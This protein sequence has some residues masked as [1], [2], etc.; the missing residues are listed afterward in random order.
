MDENKQND[1]DTDD[2]FFNDVQS[3]QEQGACGKENASD[4]G[5]TGDGFFDDASN[6]QGRNGNGYWGENPRGYVPVPT[7]S[8]KRTGKLIGKIFAAIGIA[9]VVFFSGMLTTWVCLDDGMRTLIKIKKTIDREY[10]QDVSDDEFYR[11]LF[12]AINDDLLDPY[13][14]Y[15][16]GEEYSASLQNLAGNRSGI[17]VVFSLSGESGNARTAVYRVV[18]NSPAEKAGLQHGDLIVG[19]GERETEI[20]SNADFYKDLK[21]F[22]DDRKTSAPFF[23][24]I[25]RGNEESFVQIS[26]EFYVESYVSYRTNKTSYGFV[27]NDALTYTEKGNALTCLADNTAYIKL[28]QFTGNAVA[29]FE[30][31][32]EQ[33]KADGM[34]N[35]V[36]DLRE[37]GGGYLDYVQYISKYFCKNATA[38]KPL[39]VVADYGEK[40]EGYRAAGNVYHEYFV[41]D[42]RI[43]VLAD[44]GTA[45]ASE[46]LIGCMVDY[47]AIGYE[48]ICLSQRSGVAKTYGKGIMQTTFYLDAQKKDFLKLTTA[49]LRWPISGTSIHARGILPEDGALTVAESSVGET[50]LEN[51]INLLFPAS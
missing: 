27:G 7:P 12:A 1:L 23:L 16:T 15:M 5:D 43:V 47:G 46:C 6:E 30:C 13:S 34:K 3:A 44:N 9:V 42:S 29:G 19:F 48:D 8:R 20:T 18:E 33:F 17:G 49:Q 51:A 26:K 31:V 25:M 10:Y 28:S 2:G 24:K 36:L 40:Q 4:T 45:S 11:V 14:Q 21:P 22:L 35:L 37:N 32:M 50:E 39:V 38:S 41:E